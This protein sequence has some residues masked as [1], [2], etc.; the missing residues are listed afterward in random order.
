MLALTGC[1]TA[2]PDARPPRDPATPYVW[3]TAW[4]I[5]DADGDGFDDDVDCDDSDASVWPGAPFLP[6]HEC[7]GK[8]QDCD[9]IDEGA[10]DLDGDSVSACDFDCD[11]LDPERAPGFADPLG[12]GIDQDCNGTD[13]VGTSPVLVVGGLGSKVL[14]AEAI[15]A[16]VDGDGCADIVLGE[17]GPTMLEFLTSGGTN[18]GRMLVVRGCGLSQLEWQPGTASGATSK[19]LA[20]PRADGTGDQIGAISW[21]NTGHRGHFRLVEW[22]GQYASV[23]TEFEGDATGD[24]HTASVRAGSSPTL[25]FSSVVSSAPPSGR[26]FTLPFETEEWSGGVTEW[27]GPLDTLWLGWTQIAH[28]RDADGEQE[29][30]VS[31]F[32]PGVNDSFVLVLSDP[33]ATGG[34]PVETWSATATFQPGFGH[35]LHPAPGLMNDPGAV[36]AGATAP[37]NYAGV[38][39][40]L[41]SSGPGTHV[42]DDSATRFHG[43]YPSDWLGVSADVGDVNGDGEIDVLIGAPGDLNQPGHGKVFLFL[44]P[45]EAGRA[46]ERADADTVFVGE[47]RDDHLGW[48]VLTVDLDGDGQEEAYATAPGADA[49]VGFFTGGLYRLDL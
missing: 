21:Y 3:D 15:E 31:A 43:E 29:L 8:D 5:S 22:N 19:L 32:E 27:T 44:G 34:T 42:L 38:L 9:G 28:D 4:P 24:M 25:T 16:D 11:D 39:G 14:G 2:P 7:D 36:L 30:V 12:D 23:V 33:P 20:I 49:G 48:R 47:G 1:G 10:E 6:S 41:P 45:I 46:Y 26:S 35:T 17:T 13:G 18:G 37:A 40:V